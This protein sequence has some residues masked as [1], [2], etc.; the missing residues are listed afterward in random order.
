MKGLKPSIARYIGIMVNE[1]LD[2]LKINVRKYEI[3]E[4]MITGE[5]ISSPFDIENQ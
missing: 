4:F 5:I 3:F 2:E 1:S